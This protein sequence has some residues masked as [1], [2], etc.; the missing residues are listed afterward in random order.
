[1]IDADRKENSQLTCN[2]EEVICYVLAH[3]LASSL[4]WSYAAYY[5][6]YNYPSYSLGYIGWYVL[7][8]IR[9]ELHLHRE[10]R[11]ASEPRRGLIRSMKT[12]ICGK[13]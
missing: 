6:L 11:A 13:Q 1:M 5:L 9:T 12:D 4:A 7:V 8:A 3:V 2:G 10:R